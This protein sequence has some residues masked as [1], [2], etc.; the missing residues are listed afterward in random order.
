MS[1][2]HLSLRQSD[3]L[4]F[5]GISLFFLGLLVGLIL[6]LLANPRMGLSSHLEGIMNGLFLVVLGL[7]WSRINLSKK[8]MTVAFWLA[9]YGTFANWLGILLAALWDAGE[10]L[11]VAAGG[12]R[13][14]DAAEIIVNFFLITLTFAMLSL[15]LMVLFGLWRGRH[16]SF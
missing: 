13:G 7:I 16:R 3:R 15:C 6:P 4:I 2:S 9:I 12:N 14:S 10:N 11:T 5:L 8:W 1:S